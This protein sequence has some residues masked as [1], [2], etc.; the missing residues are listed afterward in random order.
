MVGGNEG[1][2]GEHKHHRQMQATRGSSSINSTGNS[3]TNGSSRIKATEPVA[4]A[5]AAVQQP[6]MAGA[7]SHGTAPPLFFP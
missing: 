6:V 1:R 5:A 3:S 2:G 7:R 4:T